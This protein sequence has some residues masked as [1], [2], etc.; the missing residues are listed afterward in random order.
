MIQWSASFDNR[1]LDPQCLQV[2]A[3]REL[4]VAG[5][6]SLLAHFES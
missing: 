6:D 5:H 4:I 3:T 2:E 1:G